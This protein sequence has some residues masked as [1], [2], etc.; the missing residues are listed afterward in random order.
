[1]KLE[2]IEAQAR[3]A[4]SDVALLFLHGICS[5]AALWQHTFLPASAMV[6]FDSFA[7]SF[8]GHGGSEGRDRLPYT[9]LGDYVEDLERTVDRL[10]RPLIV[11]G[12]SLGGAVL[13]AYLRE[14]QHLVGAVLL[15]SVPPQGLASAGMKLFFRDWEAWSNL[16]AANQ[17]GSRHADAGS[18][19]RALFTEALE[20]EAYQAF[21]DQVEDEAPLVGWQLQGW[22]PFAPPR[23]QVQGLPPM[24]AIG[25]GRDRLVPPEEVRETAAYYDCAVRVVPGMPHM[26]MLEP[27]WQRAFAELLSWMRLTVAA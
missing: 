19:R 11:V 27:D 22:P 13:Q 12:F 9:T 2:V 5:S 3:G 14:R 6:G 17:L 8:R 1:M 23:N 7:L 25:G 26:L 21:L 10:N 16:M 4:K 24:L 18:L 20:P 15:C